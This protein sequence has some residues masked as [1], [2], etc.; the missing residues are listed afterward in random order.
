M[1]ILLI[2]LV[3][4]L[5]IKSA[6][7]W[8]G[9]L[10]DINRASFQYSYEEGQKW[11]GTVLLFIVFN[12]L[13]SIWHAINFM[14]WVFANAPNCGSSCDDP[15]L[16]FFIGL[17][18]AIPNAILMIIGLVIAHSAKKDTKPMLY[19]GCIFILITII[20]YVLLPYGLGEM[21]A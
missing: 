21:F 17:T 18:G 5:L 8:V 1:Y 16:Y 7:K 19:V 6:H 3:S 20:G 15:I 4:I 13:T 11:V 14:G 2:G 10:N 9:G 12:I